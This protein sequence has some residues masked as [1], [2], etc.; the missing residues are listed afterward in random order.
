[1]S[2]VSTTYARRGGDSLRRRP[3]E[4]AVRA[5]DIKARQSTSVWSNHRRGAVKL[6]VQE[7]VSSTT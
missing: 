5:R 4:V 2:Q 6:W 3:R 7:Q 1:M